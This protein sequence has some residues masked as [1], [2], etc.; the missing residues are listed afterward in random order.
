VLAPIMIPIFVMV[1]VVSR[2]N[3]FFATAMS[4]FPPFTPL[5]MMLRQA[6][7]GGVPA[8]QPWLGLLGIV[9]CSLAGVWAA[10]RVFRVAILMQGQPPRLADI[11]RWAIRG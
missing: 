11:V 4:L 3:G 2:P 10:S 9:A 1:P 7:P 8:W 5:L 6:M